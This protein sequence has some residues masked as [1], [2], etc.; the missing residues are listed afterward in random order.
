MPCT[1][2]LQQTSIKYDLIFADPPDNI[3]LAYNCYSDNLPL[4]V[5]YNWIMQWLV[6]SLR[7]ASTVII[8]Y[9]WKHDLEIK[10]MTRNLLKYHFPSVS[11]K[12]YLWRFTFGQHNTNDCGSG[13]RYLLRLNTLGKVINTEAIRELSD[14]QASGDKRANPD[15]RVPDDVWTFNSTAAQNEIELK[16]LGNRSLKMSDGPDTGLINVKIS[17]PKGLLGKPLVKYDKVTHD[18]EKHDGHTIVDVPRVTGNSNE[19]RDWAPTQHPELLVHRLIKMYTADPTCHNKEDGVL[20]KSK[21][22]DLFGGT[23]TVLRVGTKMNRDTDMTEI[24]PGYCKAISEE[25]W[26]KAADIRVKKYPDVLFGE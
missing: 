9:Y 6:L 2:Y 8:S 22:L 3:G 7:K 26:C 18:P 23:G 11:A 4:D 14:R 25:Q 24:D 19:R 13:F 12:T 5:Y 15:G 10:F 17:D 1:E 16:M 20:I 21:V